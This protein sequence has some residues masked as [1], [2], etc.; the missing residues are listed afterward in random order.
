[1]DEDNQAGVEGLKYAAEKGIAVV[2]MEPL[3]GGKLANTPPKEI[4]E[5]WNTADVKRT[6]AE[7]ALSWIWN[8]P[9]VSLILS[10]MNSIAMIDENIN[11]ADNSKVN[12]LSE[13]ELDIIKKAYLKYKELT[14]VGCTDCKYCMPCPTGVDIPKN[15]AI[16]NQAAV[17]NDWKSC[18]GQYNKLEESQKASACIECAKCEGLCPQKLTIIEYLK[19]VHKN[20]S[21][22]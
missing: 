9:E 17:Y 13:K 10:G 7:W 12:S 3:L 8:Q 15:F 1:M 2:V 5:I 18:A 6:P 16:Y 11:S 22:V 4:E 14:R 21:A 19:D 20:L